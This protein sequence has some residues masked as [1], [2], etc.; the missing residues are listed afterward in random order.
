MMSASS[1]IIS[2]LSKKHAERHED[3]QSQEPIS[4][5]KGYNNDSPCIN[6]SSQ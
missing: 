1:Q 3:T 5:K 6:T 4:I 2:M